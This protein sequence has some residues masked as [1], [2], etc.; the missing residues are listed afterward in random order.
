MTNRCPKC[1][2]DRFK[3]H[4]EDKR[5][6]NSTVLTFIYTDKDGKDVKEESDE[7]MTFVVCAWCNN[8]VLFIDPYKKPAQVPAAGAT[9]H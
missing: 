3:S 1:D 2:G 4:L 7:G 8:R 5:D 6:P 9:S